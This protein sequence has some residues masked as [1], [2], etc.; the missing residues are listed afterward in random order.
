MMNIDTLYVCIP[1]QHDFKM[2]GDHIY[3]ACVLGV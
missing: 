1:P 3:S 2:A